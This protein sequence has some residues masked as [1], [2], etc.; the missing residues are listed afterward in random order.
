MVALHAALLA[1]SALEPALLRRRFDAR[2]GL[3]A[4]AVALGAQALRWWCIRTLG[5]RW[6]TRV[7]VLP[8]APRIRTGPYRV[9]AHPNYVAVIAEGAALPLVHGA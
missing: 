7:L 3:P 6:T 8:G 1:G 9:L 5:H 4:L 2:V